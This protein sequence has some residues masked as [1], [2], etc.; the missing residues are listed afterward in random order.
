MSIQSF[1]QEEMKAEERA[2]KEL[3]N[4]YQ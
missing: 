2:T 1:I 3:E 4:H